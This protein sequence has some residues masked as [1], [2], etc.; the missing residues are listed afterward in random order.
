MRGQL[1]GSHRAEAYPTE[2]FTRHVPFLVLS[3]VSH[4]FRLGQWGLNSYL[5]FSLQVTAVVLTQKTW[6]VIN[7]GLFRTFYD[8]VSE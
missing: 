3:Y 1:V 7:I 5:L 4:D 2:F 8:F 6:S